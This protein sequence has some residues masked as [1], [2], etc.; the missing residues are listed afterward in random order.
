MVAETVKSL[1]ASYQNLLKLP[2]VGSIPG[3]SCAF[4]YAPFPFSQP[5]QQAA[6][7]T[8]TDDPPHNPELGAR[9]VTSMVSRV[10]KPLD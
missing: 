5:H 4:P 7:E 9:K 8:H 3:Y 10:F 2:P 6:H 1:P